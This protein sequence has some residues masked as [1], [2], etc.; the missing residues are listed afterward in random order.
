MPALFLC[1]V[2]GCF[3]RK[4]KKL[5]SENTE[6]RINISKIWEIFLN[7]LK[8]L[9]KYGKIGLVKGKAI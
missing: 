7:V 6:V 5:F 2:V 4:N 8:L 3:L 9:E 1:K